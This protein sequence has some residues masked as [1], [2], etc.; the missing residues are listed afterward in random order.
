MARD[1]LMGLHILEY[2]GLL[3]QRLEPTLAHI[4]DRLS[5]PPVDFSREMKHARANNKH[6]RVF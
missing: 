2:Q 6:A 3:L 5:E 1:A 4:A